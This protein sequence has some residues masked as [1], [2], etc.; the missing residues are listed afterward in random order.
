MDFSHLLKSSIPQEKK[1]L[2]FGFK[3]EDDSLIL[4][5]DIDEDFYAKVTMTKESITVDAI[6]KESQE[7]FAPL[8]IK[9][10]NGAFVGELRQKIQDLMQKVKDECFE[11]KD[12]SEPYIKWIKKE[13]GAD[14][15]F[16]WE[17]APDYQIFRAP[18]QKWFALIMRIPFKR[19]GAE[20]D[21]MVYVANLKAEDI[22]SL[23]D[24]KSIYPAW[25]MNK[26]YWITILLGGVT[27]FEK[28]CELT[29]KSYA[30]VQ[31]KKSKSK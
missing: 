20:S 12:L 30:L 26:K 10:A 22:P 18:N 4:K 23:V 2:K 9:R 24:N 21:E 27:D 5:K 31:E 17:E 7:R 11:S 3:K 1:L 16:L 6:D 15:E 14:G 29:K 28:L 13:F 25:H 8:D 19:L